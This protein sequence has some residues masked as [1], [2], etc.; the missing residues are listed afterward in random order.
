MS[1]PAAASAIRLKNV[2]KSFGT[3]KVLVGLDLEVKK[4]ESLVLVGQSGI[5]KS[6]LLKHV[7]GLLK[8]DSGTVEIDGVDLWGVPSR[9]R[10][11]LRRKFGMS[12]QEGALFDSMSVGENIA[13]PLTRHTKKSKKEIAARVAECLELVRLPGIEEKRP[14]ELSGGMKRRVGFARAIALQP[15]NLLFDE[16]TTGLDPITTDVVVKVIEE[17]RTRLK[18][19]A[20]TITH[21]LKVAFAIADRVG[22]LYGGKIYVDMTPK[23]FERSKDP[24][25]AAF[26]TGNSDLA[27][28]EAEPERRSEKGRPEKAG[29]AHV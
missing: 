28:P 14:S 15:E 17:M 29:E 20:I 18:P 6:V 11:T 10:D 2:S 25:V 9:E 4:G 3:K 24:H 12:F 21:D 1:A 23:E 5:G 26:V 27:P 8:P 7:I 13:F 22:L 19:S 16:P